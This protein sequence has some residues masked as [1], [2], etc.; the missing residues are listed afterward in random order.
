MITIAIMLAT[1]MQ[2]LDSTIANVALPHMQASL[3]AAQDTITWVLTSYIVASAIAI[4]L[5]GWLADRVGAKRLYLI[6]IGGFV[7]ASM[8]C[9]AAM[10]LTQMVAFR[11]MQG[12]FG[13]FIIPLAQTTML[14]IYPKEKHGQA[15]AVWSMGVMIGPIMG[16]VLGGWLTE[17]FDWRWVFYVNLPVGLLALG[18][19]WLFMPEAPRR[20]RRFDL[21]GFALLAIA[22]GA[23]QL[24]L[25]RG[26]QREWFD[27]WEIWIE[28]GL[29]ISALWMF[30]VHTATAREVVVPLAVF[31]DRN[32]MTALIFS[33]VMGVLLMASMSLMPPMLQHLFGYPIVTTGLVLAPRGIGTLI[34]MGIT[35]RVVGRVDPR[36][37]IAIGLGLTALSLWQMTGFSL[38]MDMTPVIVSGVVQGLG[39]GLIFVPLN[40]IAFATLAPQ[41]R[42]DAS[43][44]LTL[45]RS[46]G[47]SVGISI[48]TV[49]LVRNTQVSHADLAAR[50]TPFDVPLIDPGLAQSIGSAGD[51]ALT[52]LDAEINRQAL[53]ISYLNDFK[54]MMIM[55]LVAMPLVVLLRRPTAVT[56]PVPTAHPD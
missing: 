21:F 9:G 34:S 41:L 43:S 27:A 19:V 26:E 39:L 36:L 3:G 14:G 44:L 37:L 25:D 7:V 15:M 38:G 42:T 16:P 32:V 13:A 31:R 10:S 30:A 23:F 22:V 29:A 6:S 49:L 46:L 52:M 12:V 56:G 8:L 28:A 48:V 11:V 45:I 24:I 18:G 54:F 50:V 20:A 51:A 53:M 17:N 35:G 1:V 4:P 47:S 55:T 33:A 40:T 2:V 5:T